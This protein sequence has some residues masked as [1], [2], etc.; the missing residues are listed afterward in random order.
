MNI[1]RL[2]YMELV[3]RKNHEAQDRR[4]EK[5]RSAADFATFARERLQDVIMFS[6]KK[7]VFT[8]VIFRAA[9]GAVIAAGMA[10]G[11]PPAFA[12]NN[13]VTI[14]NG[15]LS[16]TFNLSWGA[17]VT[18]IS[19]T[20]VANG[21]NIVDSHD[22]GRELQTDQFLFQNIGGSNQ[23]MINPTQAG[24]GGYQAYYQHPNGSRIP[25]TGSPVASWSAGTS[26]FQAVIT[27]LDYDTGNPT[28]WVY[29][30][31]VGISSQGIANFQY[32][33]YDYQPQTYSMG[34]EVPTLY[35]DRTDAFMYP[36]SNG[37]PQTVSGSPAW[38]QPGITS[39]GWIGNVDTQDNLGIF[40]T[41]PVGMT[42][43]YG[44]FP[45]AAVS[46]A[47][48]L[49]KTNVVDYGLAANPGTILSSGF[50]VLAGTQQ[51][52]PAL[53]SQQ[54][55]AA[56]GVQASMIT[57]GVFSANAAAYTTLPGYASVGGNPT[58]P[59]GWVSSGSNTGVNGS[60][61][62]FYGS[63]GVQPFA[64][65][66]TAGVSD[67]AFLQG[68]GAFISQ[69]VA[70]ATGQ[71][72]TLAFDGAARSIDPT[73][74]L[75]VILTDVVSGH[76]IY[77][78]T[79]SITNSGFTPFFLNFTATSGSTN[80]EFLNN[81]LP[82]DFTVDVSNVSL[83]ATSV[84]EPATLGLFAIGGVALVVAGKRRKIRGAAD[85]QPR[86]NFAS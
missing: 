47:P 41:T 56:F 60:D 30:E 78:F 51:Q 58:A 62:G 16:V 52:G 12:A 53:I 27:P 28:D 26:Q 84:S 44:T 14:S 83:A 11:A 61:T 54:A 45:G 75:E 3:R 77:T 42:E 13:D 25:E 73:A 24:A 33:C 48:P 63:I 81:S 49:G 4:G 46:N 67:F 8:G 74:V 23:L 15:G 71:A 76:Q 2:F 10:V 5:R 86:E 79:P 70:T 68:Q 35:S 19:N 21:L 69:D 36:A 72:Y 39:N 65:T 38:P 66:S 32:T 22:V 17:V 55:P 85:G 80:I 9:A 50:S 20:N 82:G 31:N 6:D 59:T 64:P 7:H 37:S 29:V 34:T 1:S 18:G 43:T 40:Y 57:N